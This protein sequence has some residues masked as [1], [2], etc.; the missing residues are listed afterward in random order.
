MKWTKDDRKP[1]GSLNRFTFL[2]DFR[3]SFVY[4]GIWRRKMPNS[5]NSV[6]PVVLFSFPKLFSLQ[7]TEVKTT[8]MKKKKRKKKFRFRRFR[9]RR[10][11]VT[12]V[13][14]T[15]CLLYR[16][17]MFKLLRCFSMLFTFF[18]LR[19]KFQLFFLF[20]VFQFNWLLHYIC[21]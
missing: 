10:E 5:A 7:P 4:P 16:V 3:C 17:E 15:V 21:G 19:F 2:L 20:L 11:M 9:E 6:W 8:T 1:N 14:V 18:V 12:D 13:S